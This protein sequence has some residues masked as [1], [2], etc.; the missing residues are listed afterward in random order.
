MT[1]AAIDPV[2][3]AAAKRYLDWMQHSA[4]PF[5]ATTGIDA[6]TGGSIERVEADGSIDPDVPLRVR[7][8]ARQLFV[9]AAAYERSWYR[10]SRAVVDAL[11]QFLTQH[12]QH[13]E[14]AGFVHL[15]APDS[16][17]VDARLDLYDHAFF[18]LATALHHR[19]TG[20]RESHV[21]GARIRELIDERLAAPTG[22]W[23]EGDYRAPWRRQNP[24]MHLLEAFMAWHESD[25]A[26]GWLTY[27]SKVMALFEAHFYDGDTGLLL[28]YFAP[29]WSRPQQPDEQSVE[30]GHLLEWVW[31]LDWYQRLTGNDTEHYQRRLYTNALELGRDGVLMIDEL[32]PSGQVRARSKR[33]WPMTEYIKAACVRSAAGDAQAA[34][35]A[36]RAIDALLDNF[37]AVPVAG[38][39]VDR[40]S[41]TNDVADA[42]APASSMYHLM[43]AA[44]EVER[45]LS[46]H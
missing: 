42:R 2:F 33:L 13:S 14:R 29:D 15:L 21:C 1:T 16:S 24:H 34:I 12:A 32:D 11:W 4:L 44:L 20:S 19:V 37:A 26:G 5:W 38:T 10:G 36:A 41:A 22:G 35:E 6:N 18:L 30:P 43:A 46:T 3:L 23:Q 31:L 25:P 28:E 17:L 27:A 45:L 39:Y 40:L 9:F 7:V 8:Q